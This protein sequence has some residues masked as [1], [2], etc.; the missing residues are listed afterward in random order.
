MNSEDYLWNTNSNTLQ[1]YYSLMTPYKFDHVTIL[2][3]LMKIT[4]ISCD[5]YFRFQTPS[6]F[7]FLSSYFFL[8]PCSSLISS[9]LL[10]F[11]S[12]FILTCFYLITKFFSGFDLYH[13]YISYKSLLHIYLATSKVL[14]VYSSHFK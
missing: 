6:F 5:L 13:C 4:F 12:L 7:S 1:H 10:F 9:I 8:Y 2:M 14:T 11:S 3:V